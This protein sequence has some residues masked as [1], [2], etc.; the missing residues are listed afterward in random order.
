MMRGVKVARARVI[1]IVGIASALLIT[2]ALEARSFLAVAGRPPCRMAP[3]V[4][5]ISLSHEDFEWLEGEEQTGPCEKVPNAK[6][7]R[8]RSKP[9]TLFVYAD[10]PS[11]S[12][13]FWHVTIGVSEIDLAKPARG[14]CLTANTVGWRTLQQYKVSPLPWLDDVDGDGK[15][16]LIL[17][18]SFPLRK[19]ASSAEFG[20]TAWVYRLTSDGTLVIDWDLTRKQAR[21]IAAAYRTPLANSLQTIAPLRAEAAADLE[22]FAD[23]RCTVAA[24]E[25][26]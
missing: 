25:S 19:E 2:V 26:R 10:G 23:E 22:M 14:N 24:Q 12:G 4:I 6:W 20:L 13:R 9:F 8:K 17:W 5:R 7:I 3:S 1:V 16:E 15:A 18:A 21:E 11:G